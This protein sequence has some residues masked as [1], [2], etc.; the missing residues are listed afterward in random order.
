MGNKYSLPKK[1]GKKFCDE[2]WMQLIR[3]EYDNVCPICRSLNLEPNDKMLNAHHL[4]S[5]RVFKYRWDTNNGI[6]ICPKHHEFDL[7]LS[8]HTAP[9]GFEEWMKTYLP[10]KYGI[11][12]KNRENIASEE[13][14][15]YNY[16]EIYYSLEK[17]YKQKTGQYFKIKRI[18]M[19]LLS[20]HK[21]QIKMAR[22]LQEESISS[23]A[24][25]YEVSD[26]T[27][28]KFLNL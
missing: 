16:E 28:K 6:L 3:L 15:K 14:P 5:R 7:S 13:N 18:N 17:K 8:A 23:L 26:G 11:W 12:V 9:W 1:S 24:K 20:Q 25:K 4:I 27:M 19:Y 10:E 21:S 2:L 22:N